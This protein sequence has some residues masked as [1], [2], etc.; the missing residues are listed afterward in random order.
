MGNDTAKA[1]QSLNYKK[2]S[3]PKQKGNLL[4]HL[5]NGDSNGRA[6]GPM[7]V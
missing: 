6:M 2:I 1:H 3:N 4:V 5:R 7:E